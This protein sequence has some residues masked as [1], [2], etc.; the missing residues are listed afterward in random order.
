MKIKNLYFAFLVFFLLSCSKNDSVIFQKI[1]L[2]EA[3]KK[4]QQ[5]NKLVLIDFFSTTCIPCITL[6]RTIFRDPVMSG[7]INKHFISLKITDELSDCKDLKKKY[8][9]WGLPTVLF[10]EK[11]G[12]EVDRNCGYDGD[13][14]KYFKTI[15]DYAANK[16]T[17]SSLIEAYKSDPLDVE[18]NYRLAM[19]YVN[20]W[21]YEKDSRYFENILKLDPT[22]RH[23]YRE[24]CLLNIA[25]NEFRDKKDI[26]PIQSFTQAGTNPE[27]LSIGYNYL[28][29]YIESTAD[30]AQYLAT[31]EKVIERIPKKD[32]AYWRLINYYNAKKDPVML[33]KTL[34]RTV[35][36]LPEDT[37]YLNQYAW[38]IYENHVKDQYP[39]AIQMAQKALELEPRADQI[40]DTLAWIYF[41]TGD[42]DKAIKAMEKA[43]R[44]N[45]K[46]KRYQENLRKFKIKS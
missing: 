42:K 44:L 33:F 40:W 43:A 35:A 14:D 45:P 13:K 37:R 2:E 30:T 25:I 39:K 26:G 10:L 38:T 4:A 11:S 27:L 6:S 28:L 46:E 17:L 8:N 16:N 29:D 36:N 9:V 34:D 18:N 32:V 24:Q 41:E 19:K 7:F 12:Q 1:T 20:R 3:L 23:G 5:E 15:T 21:E 22:D 31:C